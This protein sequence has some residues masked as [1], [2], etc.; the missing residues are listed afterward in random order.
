MRALCCQPHN[1][2]ALKP[3]TAHMYLP[4]LELP[5]IVRVSLIGVTAMSHCTGNATA[6]S[7]V[8][9]NQRLACECRRQQLW[10]IVK[11]NQ[12]LARECRRQQLWG[13]HVHT[14]QVVWSLVYLTM[15]YMYLLHWMQ[16]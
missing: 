16:C 7:I 14:I 12:R 11:Q 10:G 9:Q 8:K 4:R 3:G 5:I 1:R 2:I 15:Q 13:N 6:A